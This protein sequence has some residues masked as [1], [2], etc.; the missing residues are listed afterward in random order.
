LGGQPLTVPVLILPVLPH[1]AIIDMAWKAS[2][3][4]LIRKRIPHTTTE[5]LTL[6]HAYAYGSCII[7]DAVITR[8]ALTCSV[9][10]LTV[11]IPLN[12]EFNSRRSTG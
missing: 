11:D 7:Y 2:S 6:P 10:W 3:E 5:Q 12:G 9:T 8:S 4:P 1:E